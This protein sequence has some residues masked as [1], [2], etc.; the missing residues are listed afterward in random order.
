MEKIQTLKKSIFRRK[1]DFFIIAFFVIFL[2]LP[3]INKAV[4]IDD[5]VFIYMARQILNDPLRPYSFNLDWSVYSGPAIFVADP[6]LVP[7]YIALIM[8]IF[9][10]N[11]K[12]IHFSFIIF[13]LAAALSMY[14]ISKK[15]TKIPL[16]AALFLTTSVVFVVMSHNLMLDIAFL[17]LF[18][19]SVALFIYGVDSQSRIMAIA[20]AL[21]CGLAYLAKYTGIAVF[22]ILA[23][24]AIL[25]KKPKYAVYLSI[26][27]IMGILWNIYTY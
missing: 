27:A 2:T 15:F 24:Y 10:E 9:G 26:P 18:L 5:T 22:P 20:G 13:P 23:L 25:R 12:I 4:H 11:Q 21:F 19:L 1:I 17:A 16:F 8:K 7:Y 14:Y 3:F 6:P